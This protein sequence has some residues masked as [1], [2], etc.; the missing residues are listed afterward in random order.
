[1]IVAVD[2]V[3]VMLVSVTDANVAV[4]LQFAVMVPV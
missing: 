3:T 2:G 4:A 1:M